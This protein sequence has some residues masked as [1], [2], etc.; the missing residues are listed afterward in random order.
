[1]SKKQEVKGR[2]SV[3]VVLALLAV[4]LQVGDVMVVS[5]GVV[6]APFTP[7][8][9]FDVTGW[10]GTVP[11]ALLLPAWRRLGLSCLRLLGLVLAPALY[12]VHH[13]HLA[14]AMSAEMFDELLLVLSLEVTRLTVEGFL[15]LAAFSWGGRAVFAFRA[16]LRCF[17]VGRGVGLSALGQVFGFV[18]VVFLSL[19]LI[20]SYDHG[21]DGW[22]WRL[23]VLD[24]AELSVVLVVI[25]VPG[26]THRQVSQQTGNTFILCVNN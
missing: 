5:V 11:A 4:V 3:P 14:D 7:D 8:Q 24:D 2:V 15:L 19:L 20:V 23:R 26:Q 13:H 18:T 1:M 9:P 10:R 25:A 16:L 17:G 12:L 21:A 6:A 22:A